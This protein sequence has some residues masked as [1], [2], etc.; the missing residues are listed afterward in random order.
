MSSVLSV[1]VVYLMFPLMLYLLKSRYNNTILYYLFVILIIITIGY[2]G[3]N[4]GSDTINYW[5]SYIYNTYLNTENYGYPWLVVC[6][7]ASY[8]HKEF[9]FVQILYALLAILPISVVIKKE[10]RRPFL[11]LFFLFTLGFYFSALNIMRQVAAIGVGVYAAYCFYK[12]RYVLFAVTCFFAILFHRTAVILPLGIITVALFKNKLANN[13][14]KLIVLSLLGGLILYPIFQ[15]LS[16][17]IPIEKFSEY[18]EYAAEKKPNIP[19]LFIVNAITTYFNYCFIRNNKESLVV[20][21]YFLLY[22]VSTV[23]NNLLLYNIGMNRLV[24]YFSIFSCIGL[25]NIYRIS[26]KNNL[27]TL[28]ILY[29]VLSYLYIIVS[30]GSGVFP[31]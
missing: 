12:K 16:A 22:S 13:M 20:D 9:Y 14:S 5:D 23:C 17:Y 25:V 28:F 27:M 24:Y 6:S 2:R 26:K 29:N 21:P 7:L 11:S 10:S 3:E 8:F 1:L 31:F 4:I 19:Y 30:N 18:G 15:S